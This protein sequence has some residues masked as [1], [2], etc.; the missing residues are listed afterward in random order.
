MRFN[1][2]VAQ[3]RSST[4]QPLCVGDDTGNCRSKESLYMPWTDTEKWGY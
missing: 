1:I 4:Y 2:K 3:M